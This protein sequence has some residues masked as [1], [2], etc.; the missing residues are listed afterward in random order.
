MYPD[1][2]KCT[3]QRDHTVKH[4]I[5]DCCIRSPFEYNLE[6]TLRAAQPFG[7]R[8]TSPG[9][10]LFAGA[11]YDVLRERG[12]YNKVYKKVYNKVALLRDHH[13]PHLGGAIVLYKQ[14]MEVLLSTI[15]IPVLNSIPAIL[16][17]I[18]TT[19]YLAPHYSKA[20]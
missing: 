18:Q 2:N 9:P 6:I 19:C 5:Q 11:Y 3:P 4:L 12:H 7:K 8:G 13:H 15:A 16:F 14:V 10:G 1:L 17:Y 20:L